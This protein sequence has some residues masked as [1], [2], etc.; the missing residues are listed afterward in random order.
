MEYVKGK[1]LYTIV[2]GKKRLS[3]KETKD[4][5]KPLVEALAHIHEKNICHRDLKLEN[6]IVDPASGNVK[7]IDFGFAICQS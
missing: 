4:I 1:S 2:R 3:E 6:I 5:L 7:L